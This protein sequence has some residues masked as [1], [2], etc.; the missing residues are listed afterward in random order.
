METDRTSGLLWTASPSVLLAATER[1]GADLAPFGSPRSARRRLDTVA[2]AAEQEQHRR[3]EYNKLMA[4]LSAPV[5]EITGGAEAT[6]A[7]AA[8]GEAPVRYVGD[9]SV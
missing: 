3:H 4:T 7:A 6:A 1:Q 5:P 9:S 2:Q 8:R